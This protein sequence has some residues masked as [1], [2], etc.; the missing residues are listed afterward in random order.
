MFE[1][2]H[3]SKRHEKSDLTSNLEKVIRPA[4]DVFEDEAGITLLADIPGVNK[5]G[6]EIEVDNDSLSISGQ[7][8]IE[9][10]KKL[11]ALYA[12]VRSTRYQRSF[13]LSKELDREKVD[14]QLQNGVLTIRI[15]KKEEHKPRKI[16]VSVH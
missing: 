13:S 10:P 9:I 2:K 15:P 7:V 6:L 14:A 5:N 1:N 4:V 3:L 12:D 8:N 16:A 11:D